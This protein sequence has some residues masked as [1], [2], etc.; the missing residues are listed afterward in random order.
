M[1]TIEFRKKEL[2]QNYVNAYWSLMMLGLPHYRVVPNELRRYNFNNL[3]KF[4]YEPDGSP[5][6]DQLRTFCTPTRSRTFRPS[7]PL[8]TSSFQKHYFSLNF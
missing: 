1:Y 8:S 7:S 6:L 4:E 2:P 3:S 5:L